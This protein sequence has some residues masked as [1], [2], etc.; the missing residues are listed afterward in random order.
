[1]QENHF[2]L[3]EPNQLFPPEEVDGMTSYKNIG[4]YISQKIETGVLSEGDRLPTIDQLARHFKVSPVTMRR[5][6][7]RLKEAGLVEAIRG[8][9]VYILGKDKPGGVHSD[10]LPITV[11]MLQDHPGDAQVRNFFGETF[12][13][14]MLGVQQ[15]VQE[16]ARLQSNLVLLKEAHFSS[17]EAL[18]A[19]LP[20]AGS[21]KGGVFLWSGTT[22]QIVAQ[23]ER[24]VDFPIVYYDC[25]HLL[26][27]SNAICIDLYKGA[28]KAIGHL[29]EK[30]HQRIGMI[31]STV[32][33]NYQ[34]RYQA[35]EDAF[36]EGLFET[37]RRWCVDCG[38]TILEIHQAAEKILNIPT[39]ERPTAIF[40]FNDLRAL[41][42][43]DVAQSR[44][45]CV[46][47][48]LAV[49]GFDAS[50]SALESRLATVHLP[51]KQVGIHAIALLRS[52][53]EEDLEAPLTVTL[54]MALLEGQS[55]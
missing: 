55:I 24:Q 45:I 17:P 38:E 29:I 51:Y 2:G 3:W 49:I 15:G 6:I 18:A 44:G 25:L 8:S 13:E 52:I 53:L 20:P 31:G 50:P 41:H 9:G 26:E 36:Q 14:I 28:R 39:D 40:C 34:F 11:F 22:P 35:W 7:G 43:I 21:S 46:P 32:R 42:L 19:M 5:A 10:P 33:Q 54:S 47:Q 23:L 12:S 48:D 4:R 37:D 1:M 16:D 30:G 27:G